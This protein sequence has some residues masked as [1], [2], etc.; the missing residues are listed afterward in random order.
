M[1]TQAFPQISTI[2]IDDNRDIAKVFEEYLEL[3]GI[4]VVGVGYDGKDAVDLYQKFKPS[5]VILDVMMPNF[6]GFYGLEKIKQL[7]SNAKVIMV[8][9]DTTLRTQERLKSLGAHSII[10]K[11]IEIEDLF[12]AISRAAQLGCVHN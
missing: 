7:D 11:P 10:Y 6:D 9:A 12:L 4:T 1:D 5:V 2:I 8:T 3:C